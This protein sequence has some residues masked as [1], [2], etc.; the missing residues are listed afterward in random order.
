MATPFLSFTKQKR[1]FSRVKRRYQLLLAIIT[2]YILA[3]LLAVPIGMCSNSAGQK[4]EC[5]VEKSSKVYSKFPEIQNI[6]PQLLEKEREDWFTFTP[7]EVTMV[8]RV[9]SVMMVADDLW[10]MEGRGSED[11]THGEGIIYRD[12]VTYH[13]AEIK[14]RFKPLIEMS[15]TRPIDGGEPV[16]AVRQLSDGV[17]HLKLGSSGRDRDESA[18]DASGEDVESIITGL[19]LFAEDPPES[20]TLDYC[21]LENLSFFRLTNKTFSESLNSF[22]YNQD[23]DTIGRNLNKFIVACNKIKAASPAD[24]GGLE[25]QYAEDLKWADNFGFKDPKTLTFRAEYARGPDHLLRLNFQTMK[26]VTLTTFIPRSE[27]ILSL[28]ML[29]YLAITSIPVLIAAYFLWKSQKFLRRRYKHANDD[30]FTDWY[31]ARWLKL[32]HPE[33]EA[34]NA[35]SAST[36]A[37]ITVAPPDM[38]QGIFMLVFSSIM[39]LLLIFNGVK[40]INWILPESIVPKW[41]LSEDEPLFKRELVDELGYAISKAQDVANGSGTFSGNNLEGWKAVMPFTIFFNDDGG[42]SILVLLLVFG[43]ILLGFIYIGRMF[44]KLILNPVLKKGIDGIAQGSAVSGAFGDDALGENAAQCAAHPHEFEDPYTGEFPA[45]VRLAVEKHA[46]QDLVHL[47]GKFRAALHKN[48]SSAHDFSLSDLLEGDMGEILLHTSYF[49]VKEF[50]DLFAAAL[51]ASGD[52]KPGPK[53]KNHK[54]ALKWIKG[55]KA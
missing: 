33:D 30:D 3:V 1:L 41:I 28:G 48:V 32:S 38:L 21:A 25:K 55:L 12:G 5:W 23:D 45:Q 7:R 16:F 2:A 44:E 10:Q 37:K 24:R 34:I 15:V 20:F 51:T 50:H 8:G 42:F 39:A 6:T 43:I 52:F 26:E 9:A 4:N 14:L 54:M 35:I 53:F 31:K 36:K 13:G 18:P 11:I 29:M 22:L 47:P 46:N 17:F 27:A 49:N 40:W 19:A